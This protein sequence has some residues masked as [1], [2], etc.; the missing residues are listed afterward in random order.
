MNWIII[1]GGIIIIGIS[2]DIM[3]KRIKLNNNRIKLNKLDK[4]VFSI[5]TGEAYDLGAKIIK[6]GKFTDEE[7]EE[8]QNL[9]TQ[10]L[11]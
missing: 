7:L 6:N 3:F 1:L 8:V 10:K 11:D 4:L 2:I 5:N 9:Y